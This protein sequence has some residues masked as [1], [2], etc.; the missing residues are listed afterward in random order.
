MYR[1]EGLFK[2]LGTVH[3]KLM[4]KNVQEHCEKTSG[5]G[6]GNSAAPEG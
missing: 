6:S 1:Q 3:C 5:S 4:T 2:T